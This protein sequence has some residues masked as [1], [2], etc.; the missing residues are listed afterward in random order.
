MLELTGGV[1]GGATALAAAGSIGFRIGSRGGNASDAATTGDSSNAADATTADAVSYRT[2]PD[3][4]PPAVAITRPRTSGKLRPVGGAPYFFLAPKQYTTAGSTSSQSGPM[5]IDRG[6]HVVWFSPSDSDDQRVMDFRVQRYRGKRV[7]TWWQG[8][9]A[10][11]YGSGVG[12]IM[13]SDYHKIAEVKAGDDLEADLHEFLITDRNTALIT[14]YRNTTADLRSI[15]G[16]AD[17]KILSGVVQEIDIATGK[18]LFSWDSLDH[19]DPGAS[20]Q[21][22]TTNSSDTLDYFHLNSIF[23]IDRR[24]LLI[25]SRN[26]CAVYSIAK[27]TGKINWQLGGK[28]SDFQH[29]AGTRFFYQHNATLSAPDRL[30]IFDNGSSPQREPQSRA[31]VLGLN[32][33]ARTVKLIKE[34]THP[35][36]LLADSQGS[37]QQLT[38]ADGAAAC[39]LVGWGAEPYFSQYDA[40]G[41]LALDGK[42]PDNVQSY[43]TL[44][45]D[46]QG[47]PTDDPVA[48]VGTNA[49]R[50]VTVYASW[51]GATE[52]ASWRVLAG[53]QRSALRKQAEAARAGFESAIVVNSTGPYFQ[54]V[55]LDADGSEL[56]HSEVVHATF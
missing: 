44:A 43:R 9:V 1:V 46:W 39:W 30:M 29:G 4:A 21:H 54:V 20:Y 40:A 5:I 8:A 51:N 11:G 47:R 32:G 2:R 49:A 56:G 24:T 28:E 52:V 12:V 31:L 23:E 3:L 10:T 48:T 26:T 50:G 27:D 37:F 16:L 41:T 17:G 13:D 7:L 45:G 19:V 42:L 36:K 33:K 6:G 35:A 55:A 34:L 38:D 22:A 25:S 15:G 14:A 53:S 18:L